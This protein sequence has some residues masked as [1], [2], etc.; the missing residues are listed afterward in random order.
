[1]MRIVVKARRNNILTKRRHLFTSRETKALQVS[2]ECSMET[3]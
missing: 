3:E 2:Q 1:L